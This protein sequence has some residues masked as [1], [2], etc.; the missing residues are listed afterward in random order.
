M[1]F[2]V[3][4]ARSDKILVSKDDPSYSLNKKLDDLAEKRVLNFLMD[5]VE[6]VKV[7]GLQN[8]ELAKGEGGKWMMEKPFRGR[9]D[10]TAVENFIRPLSNLSADAFKDDA[11]TRTSC[12][13]WRSRGSRSPLRPSG[14]SR[15]RPSPATPTPSRRIPS[16]R[17]NPRPT[18]S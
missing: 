1:G 14:R 10:K 8:F 13:A 7:E 11:P 3:Q 4:L 9:A 17:S 16:R 12:T 15:P 6:R 2:Y 5:K 18:W